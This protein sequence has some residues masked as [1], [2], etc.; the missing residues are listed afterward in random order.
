MTGPRPDVLLAMGAAVAVLFGL[1]ALAVEV[2]ITSMPAIGT[3]VMGV[4]R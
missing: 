4:I 1:L 3:W 2:V